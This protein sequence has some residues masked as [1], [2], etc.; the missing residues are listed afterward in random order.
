MSEQQRDELDRLLRDAPLSSTRA[1]A[2]RDRCS[3]VVLRAV[4]TP[5]SLW[6]RATLRTFAAASPGPRGRPGS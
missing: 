2:A 4:S 3:A 1:V 5:S 6:Q